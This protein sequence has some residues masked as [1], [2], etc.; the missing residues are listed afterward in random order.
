MLARLIDLTALGALLLFVCDGCSKRAEATSPEGL[1]SNQTAVTNSID[2]G[3]K[4]PS[5]PKTEAPKAD[6]GAPTLPVAEVGDCPAICDKLLRCKEGPFD[7]ASDCADACEA[8]ID[9]AKSAKTYRCVA[10]ATDCKRIKAC[11]R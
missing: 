7:T 11:T 2:G 1:P 9:D 8:S 6:G 10:R 3:S 4:K 5:R